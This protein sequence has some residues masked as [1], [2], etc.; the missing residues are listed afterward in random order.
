VITPNGDGANDTWVIDCIENFPLNQVSVFNRWG[1]I[2][3]EFENYNNTSMV[4][5]GTNTK[6][7]QVADG[8]YYYVVAIRNGGSYQGWILVRGSIK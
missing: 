4:W 5:N 1:D 8:T 2:I 7:E 6:G 3:G